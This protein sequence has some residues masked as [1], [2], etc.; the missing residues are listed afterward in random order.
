[1]S[2][3]QHLFKKNQTIPKSLLALEKFEQSIDEGDYCQSFALCTNPNEEGM[4]SSLYQHPSFTERFI[5]FAYADD[6]GAMYALWIFDLNDTLENAPVVYINEDGEFNII[7]SNIDKLLTIL[8]FDEQ[9]NDDFYY[10]N[11]DDY[12]PSE[13]HEAY[14]KWLKNTMDLK[15]LPTYEDFDGE[16]PTVEKII[17]KAKKTYET[18]FLTWM[19]EVESIYDKKGLSEDAMK[20]A[21]EAIDMNPKEI[22]FD[23]VKK[24]EPQSMDYFIEKLY[25]PLSDD[26]LRA[27]FKG[28]GLKIPSLGPLYLKEEQMRLESDDGRKWCYFEPYNSEV[29]LEAMPV[30]TSFHAQRNS[31][32]NFPYYIGKNDD[33]ATVESKIGRKYDE[34]KDDYLIWKLENS[35][36]NFYELHIGFK[37]KKLEKIT[38]VS[39]FCLDF[40][41]NEAEKAGNKPNIKDLEETYA[42]YFQEAIDNPKRVQLPDEPSVYIELDTAALA[43]GKDLLTVYLYLMKTVNRPDE[44][45]NTRLQQIMMENPIPREKLTEIITAIEGGLVP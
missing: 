43:L 28:C 27:N 44:V 7:A 29:S 13:E 30:M 1:M 45:L 2:Q 4:I 5:E 24:I 37:N 42:H 41:D 14:K 35:S 32:L 17:K 39:L 38:Q 22:V 15:I 40:E 11:S 18:K 3:L 21:I 16:D 12:E 26:D 20:H 8:S 33:Y 36:G 19:M 6:N 10:K 31:G 25:E 34:K 23:K 9:C